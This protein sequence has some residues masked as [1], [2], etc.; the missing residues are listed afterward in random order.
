MKNSFVLYTEYMDQIEMLSMEQRGMLFTTIMA[1]ASE[2]ALPE[3]YACD[4]MVSMAFSFIKARLDKDAEKYDSIVEARRRAGK[5]GGRPCKNDPE[6]RKAKETDALKENQTKA[7]KANAFFEKQTKAKKPDNDNVNDSDNENNNDI[8]K[9]FCTEPEQLAPCQSNSAPETNEP[10]VID[11][12]L[13]DGSTYGVSKSDFDY[14]VQ[15]YK[16]VDVM[17]E[18]RKMAGWCYGNPQKR[19]TQRGIKRFITNWLSKAQDS[20]Q[21][22]NAAKTANN[23]FNNFKQR[24]YDYG[25]LEAQLLGMGGGG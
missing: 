7:K 14:Y 11:M 19:K 15:L 1:Y 8:L 4:G 6:P 12:L 9:T 18:L 17:A 25:A 13:I 5:A 10:T 16:G 21:R 23:K 22:S 3:G 24:D 20:G 2:K